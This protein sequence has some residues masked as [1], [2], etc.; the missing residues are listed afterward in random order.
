MHVD[1][2]T[3]LIV[4]LDLNNI[5]AHVHDWG[6]LVGLRVVAEEP[7]RFSRIIASNT[8]L[9]AT[10]RG[11]LNDMFSFIAYPLFN[12]QYG[13]KDQQLG[14]NLLEAMDLQDG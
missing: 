8:S 12:F 9:I 1:K 4:E 2:M 10:G 14:K 6:G 11:V 5:T 7:D 3:Q 13:F